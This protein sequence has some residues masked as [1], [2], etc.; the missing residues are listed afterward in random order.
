MRSMLRGEIKPHKLIAASLL[1]FILMGVLSTS[2][3]NSTAQARIICGDGSEVAVAT[4]CPPGGS[5]ISRAEFVLA[6]KHYFLYGDYQSSEKKI[7]ARA[8]GF[9]H[10]GWDLVYV[11]G[12][13]DANG[14]WNARPAIPVCPDNSGFFGASVPQGMGF[15]VVRS[16][17]TSYSLH[18][19]T[20][21]SSA[22]GCDVSS[23]SHSGSS[24]TGFN[25]LFVHNFVAGG[26]NVVKGVGSGLPNFALNKRVSTAEL[27]VY[28]REGQENDVCGD[29][30]VFTKAARSWLYIPV[31]EK[32]SV[33]DNTEFAKNLVPK[34]HSKLMYGSEDGLSAQ[35]CRIDPAQAGINMQEKISPRKSYWTCWSNDVCKQHKQFGLSSSL[36]RDGDCDS[37]EFLARMSDDRTQY[38]V[39]CNKDARGADYDGITLDIYLDGLKFVSGSSDN[40]AKSYT[41]YLDYSPYMTPSGSDGYSLTITSVRGQPS[42]T[43]VNAGNLNTSAS[44]AADAKPTC[45]ID[46]VGWIICPAFNFLAKAN[47]VAFGF[48]KSLLAIQP[49]LITD[50]ATQG[51]WSTFRDLAN[52]AFVV[53]FLVIVYSQ[54]TSM[55]VSNYGIKKLLPK[56][57]IAAIL[58]NI[59]FFICAVMVDLSNVVGG[60]LYSLLANMVTGGGSGSGGGETWSGLMTGLLVTGI[61]VLLIVMIVLCPAVL[62]AAAVTLF[63][64]IA[65]Q[66][67]V[68]LL[69]VISPLAFV[70]YLLPNT[71]SLFKKWW[72]AFTATLLVYPIIGLL[73]GASTLASNILMSVAGSSNGD[74]EQ[75][76]KIVA[77]GVMGIPLLAAPSI[78]KGSMAAAGVV[79]TKL[80]GL[81]DRANRKAGSDVKDKAGK[82]LGAF[83]NA[84]TRRAL[85]NNSR[86]SKVFGVRR[87]MG[88]RAD[89]RYAEKEERAKAATDTFN[90][91]DQK[92]STRQRRSLSD[93]ETA[94]KNKEIL[95]SEVKLDHLQANHG[96]HTR[97]TNAGLDLH[98]A[99]ATHKNEA[100]AQHN[101]VNPN[102]YDAL[103]A[104][105]DRLQ[106]AQ[107]TNTSRYAASDLG[108]QLAQDGKVAQGRLDIV[109]SEQDRDYKTSQVG[110]T[111]G[112]DKRVVEG[113]IKNADKQMDVTYEQSTDGNARA[114]T[115]KRLEGELDIA[116]GEQDIQFER[117]V[118]G[119]S[120]AVVKDEVQ[121]RKAAAAAAN[122]ELSVV[123]NE[124]VRVEAAA[125]TAKVDDVKA[126]EKALIDSLATDEG[127]AANPQYTAAAATLKAADASKRVATNLSTAATKKAE[128]AF[129]ESDE[130]RKSDLTTRVA[131]DQLAA[132][133]A[134]ED[135]VVS[136]LQAGGRDAEGNLIDIDG[137]SA[138]EVEALATDLNQADTQKRVQT[139]RSSAGKRAAD[140]SYAEAVQDDGT[141]LAVTAGGIEGTAGVSQAKAVAKQTIID[142]FKKG[143]AAES[144]LLSSVKEDV[145]LTDFADTDVLDLPDEKISAMGSVIAKRQHMQ[146]HI[147]LWE[148]MG[149]LRQQ[150]EAE[151]A[152][153]EVIAD[154]VLKAEALDKVKAK[155]DKLINLQQQVMSDKSKKPFGIGDKEQGDATVGEFKTDIYESTRDRILTHL[156]D[157]ALSSMD[158]DDMRLI[159]EMGRDGKL[160]PE[161]VKKIQETF[162]AWE[163]NPNLKHLLKDKSRKL[164]EPIVYNDYSDD[165][166]RESRYDISGL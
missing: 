39:K 24:A 29:I 82:E 42:N 17:G 116:R 141:G 15:A 140:V 88:A 64:L 57:I 25:N 98:N 160:G 52:I 144:T 32:A 27:A 50:P 99:E 147:K 19:A 111:Q 86:L 81:Q 34:L 41:A 51:A 48:L 156:T 38:A 158:P 95:S 23:S 6:D 126:S 162:E 121:Q 61:S 165:T 109:K 106:T 47:D 104:S 36:H 45:S 163:N 56:I 43:G 155:E 157:G 28:N 149:E 10:G 53:A 26:L 54:V 58:V 132:S 31:G 8:D 69:V 97:A 135:A 30:L 133:K 44:A 130:G 119:Q 13:K 131:E 4:D 117:S 110:Q 127:A 115:G 120:Q 91:T 59:S 137:L 146:S 87:R 72:K 80:A 67:F 93:Q 101:L 94:S 21:S 112:Q 123:Q 83:N 143:V 139:Q 73:F 16:S 76:L 68:I 100:E 35:S 142:S 18:K 22:A 151:K 148:R 33:D 1:A 5:F 108:R 65:R 3:F 63:I 90:A 62:L 60:S 96:L 159:Y 154:P 89:A 114:Q 107:T 128:Q 49:K 134:T 92:A 138:P 77:L 12:Q 125:A 150:V 136:E 55:G 71:E 20:Q 124:G 79:G 166:T 164:L 9:Y 118:E 152:S 66:A 40:L 102:Q 74:D 70:A 75:L 122:E 84:L 85:D 78:L 129:I 103:N 145:I 153:A 2:I 161:H 46:G 113:D 7:N 37:D 14:I 105:K 11:E